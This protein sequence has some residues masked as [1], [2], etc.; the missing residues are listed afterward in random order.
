MTRK[1]EDAQKAFVAARDDI[2]REMIAM[3]V[4]IGAMRSYVFTDATLGKLHT[5]MGRIQSVSRRITAMAID[6]Q[7]ECDIALEETAP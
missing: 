7:V 3:S 6:A 2:S 4:E 1:F 5:M